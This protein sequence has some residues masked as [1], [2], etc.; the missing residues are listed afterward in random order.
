MMVPNKSNNNKKYLINLK[1][2]QNI[3]IS[4]NDSGVRDEVIQYD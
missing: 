4:R 1:R 2:S 3:S